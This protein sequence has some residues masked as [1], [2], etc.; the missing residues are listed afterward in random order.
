MDEYPLWDAAKLDAWSERS[1]IAT[2]EALARNRARFEERQK[3]Q[4]AEREA[5]RA[6]Y[7]AFTATDKDWHALRNKVM[8]RANW[9]CEACLNADARD[10]HHTTYNHGRLPP[11]WELKAVCRQCHAR[12][13][14]ETDE[15]GA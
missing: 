5:R 8:L 10:V 6:S 9:R 7:S 1:R 14:S 11:A 4:I 3:E 13:H 15:W 12:L 2:E